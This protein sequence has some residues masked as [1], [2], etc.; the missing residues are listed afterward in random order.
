MERHFLFQRL[1]DMLGMLLVALKYLESGG[2]KVLQ[3]GVAG[4][5]NQDGFERAIDRLV[6]CN[7]LLA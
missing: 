3:L 2:Q 6:V 1:S 7:L 5:G 4:V